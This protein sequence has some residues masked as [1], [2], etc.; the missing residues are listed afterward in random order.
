[1]RAYIRGQ[2]TGDNG[3]YGKVASDGVVSIVNSLGDGDATGTVAS[4]YYSNWHTHTMAVSE[5][6]IS[7]SV[8]TGSVSAAAY[9]NIQASGQPQLRNHSGSSLELDNILIYSYVPVQPMALDV[10]FDLV[11]DVRIRNVGSNK[12]ITLDTVEALDDT[13]VLVSVIK[14][15]VTNAL[16]GATVNATSE[17]N[18]TITIPN[19]LLTEKGYHDLLLTDVYAQSGGRYKDVY[20][21]AAFINDPEGLID[22]ATPVWSPQAI[23]RSKGAGFSESVNLIYELSAREEVSV[24][25]YTIGGR[26]VTSLF[27]GTAGPETLI[28]EWKGTS[29]AGEPVAPGLYL[30]KVRIGD[31][32][33]SSVLAVK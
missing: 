24:E 18:A 3:Y 15:G 11:A 25:I 17:S 2:K 21:E 5:S 31:S 9:S 32:G 14:D 6:N 16:A 13:Q 30:A 27:N 4:N 20:L 23:L 28:V 26:L 7:Y 12:L 8:G 22:T 10:R 1:M 29:S 33:Y 19:A